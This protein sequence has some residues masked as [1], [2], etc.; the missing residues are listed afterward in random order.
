MDARAC[1]SAQGLTP[2]WAIV[3]RGDGGV[4]LLERNDC[5]QR[6][7]AQAHAARRAIEPEPAPRA[8]SSCLTAEGALLR[9][10]PRT[11]RIDADEAEAL[12]EAALAHGGRAGLAAAVEA[13]TGDLLP[14]DR[15]APWAEPRRERLTALRERTLVTLAAAHL[16][17]DCP[18]EAVAAAEQVLAVAAAEEEAHRL[19]IEAYVRQGLRRRAVA[20]YH[21][22]REAL[23]EE[24]GVRPGPETERLHRAALDTPPPASRSMG[25]T[26]PAVVRRPPGTPLRGRDGLL[27]RLLA[28]GSPPVLLLTGEA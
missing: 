11:V 21:L 13:F 23:D 19:L 9:L 4:P 18:E 28:A 27:A 20:Q 25:P 14:E 17:A 5:P 1:G 3:P 8:A 22:C 6:G 16:A 10:D 26:L 12:A 7:R 24:F 15:Y 2:A